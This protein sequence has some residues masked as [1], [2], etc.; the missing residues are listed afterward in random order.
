MVIYKV[1]V[2]RIHDCIPVIAPKGAKF[3]TAQLQDGLFAI[4][5]ECDEKAE[6]TARNLGIY[7]TGRNLPED[8]PGL[9]IATVQTGNTVWHIYDRGES[10]EF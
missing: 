8:N 4:W 2:A 7:A 10:K 1:T 3:L 6:L 5:F 9:Y